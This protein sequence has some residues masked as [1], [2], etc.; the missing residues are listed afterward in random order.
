M[1]RTSSWSL[2]RAR[3]VRHDA[4]QAFIHALK[5]RGSCA[6]SACGIATEKSSKSEKCPTLWNIQK[7]N[8][9][10]RYQLS[11]EVTEVSRMDIEAITMIFGCHSMCVNQPSGIAAEACDQQEH[12]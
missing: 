4:G 12:A 1:L 2:S 9:L 11:H 8:L 5:Y 6:A 10:Q 7:G 3:L